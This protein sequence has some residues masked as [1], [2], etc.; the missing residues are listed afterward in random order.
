MPGASRPTLKTIAAETGLAVTIVSR[1]LSDAP[2]IGAQTK[3]QVREVARRVGY[4]P[5]RAGVR[6]RT[7]RSDV[8]SILMSQEHDVMGS[9]ARLIHAFASE[10]RDT[11]FHPIVTP[12]FDDEDPLAQLRYLRDTGSADAVVIDE[13][14]PEDPRVAFLHEHA[15]PFVT[16]GRSRMGV[17]HGRYDFDNERF[18][19]RAVGALA[20]RGRRRL[21][22]V[23]PPIAQAYA[24]DIMAGASSVA[25]RTGMR[26]ERLE[27]ASTDMASGALEAAV[28]ERLRQGG[29]DAILCSSVAVACVG[30]VEGLGLAVG[31]EIDIAAKEPHPVLRRLRARIVAV[32]EDAAGAGAF[33]A[34]AAL[35]AIRDPEAEPMTHLDVP[36]PDALRGRD[37]AV[38]GPWTGA[39]DATGPVAPTND[40]GDPP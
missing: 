8:V 26:R 22:V 14:R 13:G 1:A 11:G 29:V 19:A 25:G 34:R 2:D 7:G 33:L 16:N 30:A 35:A 36:G 15:I 12:S 32:R 23:G 18:A 3:A 4:R 5:N 40:P 6:L 28:A 39:P 38:R 31:G 20:E 27:D 37:V 10:L 24:Q 9:T 17:P 21:L